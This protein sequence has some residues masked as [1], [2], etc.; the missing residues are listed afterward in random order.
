MSQGIT[1]SQYGT[2]H[3][4]QIDLRRKT[5][6]NMSVS[7]MSRYLK[8]SESN[9]LKRKKWLTTEYKIMGF[10]IISNNQYRILQFFVEA[11]VFKKILVSFHIPKSFFLGTN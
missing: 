7:D 11:S 2:G 10:V 9:K 1:Q 4:M 6:R 3:H 8:N 5:G